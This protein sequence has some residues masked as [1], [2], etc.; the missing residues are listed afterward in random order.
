MIYKIP[1]ISFTALF[2]SALLLIAS[3]S[4][5]FR[6]SGSADQSSE[7]AAKAEELFQDAL[8]LASIRDS[9][10]ARLRLLEAMRLWIEAGKPEKAAQAALQLGDS[11]KQIR[12]YHDALYYYK[13][14]LDVKSLPD[15]V[16]LS[17]LNIIALFYAQ[18]YQDDLALSA[19]TESLDQ[20][21]ALND[22]PAQVMA[23][24]DMAGLYHRQNDKT[25]TLTCITQ[26]Q[27]LNKQRGADADPALLYLLGQVHQE[28]GLIAEA[29]AAF[30]EAM[31]IYDKQGNAEGKVKTLCSLSSIS[32]LS[33][34]KELALEQATEARRLGDALGK[35]YESANDKTSVRDLRWRAWLNFARAQCATGQKAKASRS[36]EMAIS[37]FEGAWLARYI[38]TEASSIASREETQI[39]Y[40][41]LVD[42]FMELGE[43]EKAYAYSERAK[44]RT[45][46]NLTA[47]QQASPPSENNNQSSPLNALSRSITRKRAELLSS[48]LSPEQ[49]ANL[50]KD[51]SAAERQMREEQ[52]KS[53]L[54]RSKEVQI[55]T[56]RATVEQLQKQLAQDQ[57]QLVQFHLG[58]TRSFAWLFAHGEVFVATLPARKDIED[59]VGAYLEVLA[60]PP[61]FLRMEKDIAKL[62]KQA[63][64]LFTT[65]FGSLAEKI[66]PGQRLIVVPGGLLHYLPF[67]AL[68]HNGHYLIEDHEIS[69]SP[70]A[71]MMGLWQ[72]A[73]SRVDGEDKMELLAIGAS[74][75]EPVAGA[76]VAGEP[77][78]SGKRATTGSNNSERRTPAA[79]GFRRLS[80]LPKTRD[81]VQYITNLFPSDRRRLL[82]GKDSTE[83]AFKHEPLR[84]YRRLHFA[85]H[86]L[87]D[88]KSPL[89]SAVV[90]TRDANAEED[91]LLDVREIST[92]NLDCDLVVVS[93]CQTGR[94]QLLAGEGIVGLS[95]AFLR[96]G[97]RSVVVS[98]WNVSDISTSHLMKDFYQNLTGGLSNVAA[99]RKA[100]LQMLGSGKEA[101]HPYYWSSFILTGKP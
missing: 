72:N 57:T 21:R 76:H 4:L 82:M 15:S 17:A 3:D 9:K 80:P 7:I 52:L 45:I 28:D 34:Q 84:R 36:Y 35:T 20:A 62:R 53:E 30:A 31:A 89:R 40:R 32:L 29:K 6:Q 48:N 70:S 68:I 26:A 33:S 77:V 99:L 58:E 2:L 90:L 46:L 60:A 78:L 91:G 39:V 11:Y 18:L 50:Q 81:E 65:L 10:S 49:Q 23:L 37:Q 25:H 22:L 75:F 92:L 5:A 54:A 51:I 12:E 42:L 100:K 19:F 96:A 83:E 97:A 56:N 86:S 24:T 14:A 1:S 64:A 55:W 13:R 71:S 93:A 74:D 47:A 43:V 101:R 63:E 41:E 66:E 88:E 44:A 27:D 73:K 8:H 59:S 98:L 38:L 85:T 87:I 67:E 69:Y 79:R 16:K 94:G 95:W 61:I